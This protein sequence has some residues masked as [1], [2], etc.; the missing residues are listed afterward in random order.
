M[1]VSSK[2]QKAPSWGTRSQ[3]AVSSVSPRL[4]KRNPNDAAVVVFTDW[5]MDQGVQAPASLSLATTTG[6]AVLAANLKIRSLATLSTTTGPAV[7][8][9]TVVVKSALSLGT[10]TGPAVLEA[11]I[12]VSTSS[13]VPISLEATTEPATL[14][15]NIS[16]YDLPRKTVNF[17]TTTGNA[18]FHVAVTK[19]EVPD[20]VFLRVAASGR[21]MG[22]NYDRFPARVMVTSRDVSVGSRPNEVRVPPSPRLM[23]AA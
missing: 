23:R 19:G 9:A 11:F 17:R 18:V 20:I 14:S 2:G 22:V 15:A 10:E 12:T 6:P 4:I 21:T 3:G 16:A 7:F 1:A 13:T 5:F 8:A